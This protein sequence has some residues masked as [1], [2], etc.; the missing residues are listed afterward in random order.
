MTL[1][2]NFQSKLHACRCSDNILDLNFMGT[3]LDILLGIRHGLTQCVHEIPVRSNKS[4]LLSFWFLSA[5]RLRFNFPCHS[6]L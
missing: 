3:L 2:G 5:Q 4:R 6:T 1:T